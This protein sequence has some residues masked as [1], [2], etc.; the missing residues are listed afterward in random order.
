MMIVAAKTEGITQ[1]TV[2]NTL[3][4]DINYRNAKSH[5]VIDHEPVAPFASCSLA[6]APNRCI[7]LDHRD[8][9]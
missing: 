7:V 5:D 9:R 4:S 6:R 8:L 3:S 1:V 2:I